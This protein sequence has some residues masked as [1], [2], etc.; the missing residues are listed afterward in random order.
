MAIDSVR[1]IL[2]QQGI[3]N[4][5]IGWNNGMVQIDNK[6]FHK[7]AKVLAG[8]SYDDPTAVNQALQTFNRNN[9]YQGGIFQPASS[10]PWQQ[11]LVGYAGDPNAGYAEL[12][13]IGKVIN[14]K[15]ALGDTA[16]VASAQDWLGKV[17]NSMGVV[18]QVNP[19][20]R[21]V[22]TDLQALRDQINNP[23]PYDVYSSPEYAA[24]KAQQDRQAGYVTRQTQEALGESGFARS[25]NLTDRVQ[26]IQNEA[27][28]YLTTQIV[29]QLISANETK[30]Q[31]GLSNLMNLVSAIQGQQKTYDTRQQTQLENKKTQAEIDAKTSEQ[32]RKQ[33]D[34][35]LDAEWKIAEETGTIT[36]KL[37]KLTGLK[38]G[39]KTLKAIKQLQDR[40][41]EQAR[42]AISRANL[43]V[44]QGNLA[45]RG[46]E[47]EQKNKDDMSRKESADN[48][49]AAFEELDKLSASTAKKSDALGWLKQNKANFNDADYK[50]LV[51]YINSKDSPFE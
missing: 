29:P 42:I 17:N 21:Q 7:P 16:G 11:R 43:G 2:N 33:L 20:D 37:A 27:N 44:A 32:K 41:D 15:T 1:K 18:G 34:A 19:Y 28:E 5:R 23:K 30:R 31:Q 14:A 22:N 12:D 35:D 24:A 13:R 51:N 4:S 45:L 26:R 8:T 6:D 49:G 40:D 50:A 39:T 36:P 9:L 25:T 46:K 38:A 47:L 10:D 48:Y 3:D